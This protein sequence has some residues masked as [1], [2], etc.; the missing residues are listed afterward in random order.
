MTLNDT[1]EEYKQ[2]AEICANTEYAEKKSVRK[3]NQS[4]N[5]MYEIVNS[6]LENFGGSGLVEFEK[7]LLVKENRTNVWAAVHLLEKLSPSKMAEDEALKIIRKI[8]EGDNAEALGFQY[9]LE[10]WESRKK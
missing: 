1:I 9:W 5:R 7:L 3:H 4:V 8:A 2:L 10:E 6:L